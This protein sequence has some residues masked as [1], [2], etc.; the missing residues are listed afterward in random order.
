MYAN[1]VKFLP[2]FIREKLE[3]CH[4]FHAILSNSGWLFI[5][6]ILRMVVGL[7]VGVWV[8][9]YL[10][11]DQ[12]GELTYVVA[13]VAIFQTIVPMGLDNIVIR[14]A[15]KNKEIANEILGTVFRIRIV[16]GFIC[17]LSILAV[18]WFLENSEKSQFLIIALVAGT[19]LFQSAD[20]VDLWF[21]SQLRSKQTV[22][23]KTIAIL[24]ATSIKIALI[25]T[26]QPL[27]A[28]GCVIFL[29][30]AVSAI[31]LAYSY[32]KYR[33]SKRWIASFS[34]ARPFLLEG[35]PYLISGLMLTLYLQ[36]DKLMLEAMAGKSE[37]GVYAVALTIAQAFNFFPLILCG[38]LAPKMATIQD[39][40]SREKFF[41][42]LLAITGWSALVISIFIYALSEIIIN[43]IYGNKF[44]NAVDVL[45]I[46]AISIVPIYLSV[47]ND[48]FV[49]NIKKSH[50]TLIRTATGLILNIA[51]NVFFI[52]K[53]GA[54]G[55]AISGLVAHTVSNIVLYWIMLPGYFVMSLHAFL[56][57]FKFFKLFV[58]RKL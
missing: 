23:S 25:L 57:P 49:L 10:G 2:D 22:I 31:A 7:L 41:E 53:F 40:K 24:L 9:R 42:K 29:E 52:P 1:W 35:L 44:D 48:Y 51:L 37:V 54:I 5:D 50:L 38:S 34:I 45:K 47:V 30:A 20:T 26:E 58:T 18:A 19:M 39:Q 28:F 13:L 4:D 16:S 14:E 8:A 32:R 15:S 11:P 6:K 56:Y 46:A 33:T 21:Q 12:F 3:G 27:V 43:V 55:A 17:Y 36:M